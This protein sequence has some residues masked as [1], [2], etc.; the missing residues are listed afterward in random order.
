MYGKAIKKKDME[1]AFM[2]RLVEITPNKKFIAVLNESLMEVWRERGK[3]FADQAHQR[4]QQ[5]ADLETKKK[6]I[7][8]MREDGSYTKEEFL[9]RKEGIEN[10]IAAQKIALSETKIDQYDIEALLAY[11]DK[12]AFD[13]ARQWFDLHTQPELRLRFQKLIF[14]EGIPYARGKTF[15]TAKMGRIFELNEAFGAKKSIGVAPA[16]IEPAF[17]P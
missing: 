6:R 17:T 5:L 3:R 2:V 12:L 9:E 8:E 15:G 13:L 7:Y 16:G 11:S 4:E 10:Q 14:P 1:D